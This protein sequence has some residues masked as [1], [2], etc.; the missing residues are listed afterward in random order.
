MTVGKSSPTL[1]S[2]DFSLE[3]PYSSGITSR[4][5]GSRWNG[6][7]GIGFQSILEKAL[8]FSDNSSS[9]VK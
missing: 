1:W 5:N 9:E 4:S 6:F 8:I 3:L 2:K 7:P